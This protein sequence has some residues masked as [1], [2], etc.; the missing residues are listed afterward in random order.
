MELTSIFSNVEQ[1]ISR[2]NIAP[3]ELL[4]RQTHIRKMMN[5]SVLRVGLAGGFNTGKSTLVNA[6]IGSNIVPMGSDQ[7]TTAIPLHIC[8]S[9][10]YDFVIHYVNGKKES[11][12]RSRQKMMRKYMPQAYENV[13]WANRKMAMINDFL[14]NNEIDESFFTLL[15]S[16]CTIDDETIE[17]IHLK[18]PTTI[19]K[20]NVE[21]VD[22]PAFD[23]F[24]YDSYRQRAF[25]ELHDCD[26]V[27]VTVAPQ[28]ML[29]GDLIEFFKSG[30]LSAKHLVFAITMSDAVAYVEQEQ[31]FAD[32]KQQLSERLNIIN[33][34]VVLCPSLLYLVKYGI[35]ESN[36][37]FS[38][39][40]RREQQDMMNAFQLF[41]EQFFGEIGTNKE[42]IKYHNAIVQEYEVLSV[43]EE[44]QKQAMKELA[45]EIRKLKDTRTMPLD[46]F[47]TPFR[48]FNPQQEID[49]YEK[50]YVEDFENIRNSFVKIMSEALDKA[51]TKNESQHIFTC[52]GVKEKN[53]MCSKELYQSYV[54]YIE[55]LLNL[56]NSKREELVRGFLHQYNINP[57]LTT[58]GY[59]LSSI[60]QVN[61]KIRY[62]RRKLTTFVFI[63]IFKRLTTIKQQVADIL[64]DVADRTFQRPS[65]KYQ[66][67]R[68]AAIVRLG[69]QYEKMVA[70]I[71]TDNVDLITHRIANED[72]VLHAKSYL[73]GNLNDELDYLACSIKKLKADIVHDS[74]YVNIYT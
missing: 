55:A 44:K 52:D 72:T 27:I 32:L 6:F 58:N 69:K 65:E 3:T 18:C 57:I 49:S 15:S 4:P 7:G 40:P 45:E 47:L 8:T 5:A 25:R 39:I 31:L 38:K 74:V 43:M 13:G 22:L 70:K 16:I 35:L 56:Y 34:T 19:L 68:S 33:A 50:Q 2:R 63:R 11:Y 24:F 60:E 20:E 51:S 53:D 71:Y 17:T 37:D 9:D 73:Y 10:Q 48:E 66:R 36:I 59:K 1:I 46:L 62:S 42:K 41:K 61:C 14:G 26:I 67:S 21:L 64:D 12:S 23:S 28:K 30:C 29:N 54:R